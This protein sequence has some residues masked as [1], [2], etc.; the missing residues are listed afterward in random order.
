M[1]HTHT[2]VL[3]KHYLTSYTHIWRSSGSMATIHNNH[4]LP[5]FGAEEQHHFIVTH[6]KDSLTH[7]HT[8]TRTVSVYRIQLH[9]TTHT[10][11][12]IT[13]TSKRQKITCNWVCVTRTND[14]V[15]LSTAEQAGTAPVGV[16][17]S[18]TLYS[19]R[20]TFL[21]PTFLHYQF[22]SAGHILFNT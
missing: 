15:V 17:H 9:T 7:T 10:H 18:Y 8:H 20:I 14:D 2:N 1:T 16:F 3:H 4:N 12:T 19:W 21:C 6:Q 22:T 5:W 11:N 13:L